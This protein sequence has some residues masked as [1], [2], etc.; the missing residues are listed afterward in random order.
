MAFPLL[1]LYLIAHFGWQSA[2][3][4]IGLLVGATM[5]LPTLLFLRDRPE[6][7]GLLPDG[8]D[9]D[10]PAVETKR[11]GGSVPTTDSW[12]LREVLLDATFWKLLSFGVTAGMICTGMVFHQQSILATRG[13]SKE[14]AMGLISLQAVIATLA[15]LP[16]GWLTDR[17]RAEQLLAGSMLL[18]A[19]SILVVIAMPHPSWGFVFAV[20][21]G[22]VGSIFRSAGTVVWINFYGRAN[23]GVIRGA[24]MSAMILA[25]AAGPIPLAMAQDMLGTYTPA[26]IAYFIIPLLSML[27]VLSARQPSH[28][29]R[30][31]R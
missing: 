13:I 25:A 24:A 27:L 10:L 2:W 14:L 7:M 17:W 22:L 23:Q 1:N 28:P 12:T 31:D 26:L 29:G 3:Q 5:V 6:E 18:L 8:D 15:T 11:R 16:A 21:M 30:A 20:L 9:P 4:I 19:L